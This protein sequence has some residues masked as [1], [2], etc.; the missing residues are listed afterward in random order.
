M[1]D[2]EKVA[3]VEA[4]LGR[5]MKETEKRLYNLFKKDTKYKFTK[6]GFGNLKFEL[7]EEK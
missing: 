7:I 2:S 3:E 4:M 6:D 5:P 1:K